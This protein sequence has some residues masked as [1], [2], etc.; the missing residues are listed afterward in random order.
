MTKKYFGSLIVAIVF[1]F[2]SC[3]KDFKDLSADSSVVAD[4]DVV[5]EA[6]SIDLEDL[7]SLAVISD[8]NSGGREQSGGLDDRFACA[9]IAR[10]PSTTEQYAG[11]IEIDFGTD[12]CKDSK[13]NLRKGKMIINYKGK[14]CLSGSSVTTSLE[15]Y[16]INDLK[17]EGVR[18]TTFGTTSKEARPIITTELKD[19]KVTWPDGTFSTHDFIHTRTWYRETNPAQDYWTVT[20]SGKGTTK[21]GVKYDMIISKDLLYKK[22]CEATGVFIA[23]AGIKTITKDGKNIAIDYGNG[24]CNNL[25]TVTSNGV[26]KVIEIHKKGW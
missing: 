10:T 14:R 3:N 18:T 9:K 1:L 4:N 7:S 16:S 20:G 25:V 22:Q 26:S 6:Y 8:P 23:V 24:I 11:S 19:G 15:N 5:S 17:I 13:G 2:A 21:K 12:G